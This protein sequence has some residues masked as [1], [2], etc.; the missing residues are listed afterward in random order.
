MTKRKH[1]LRVIPLGGLDEIGK[2]MTVLEFGDDLVVVDAGLMFPDVELPGV[3]PSCP[4]TRTSSSARTSSAASSSP[5]DTSTT[6]AP[7]RTSCVTWAS[8]CPSSARS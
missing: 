7:C 2:N 8:P 3:D 1:V 4:T 5:T 6:P